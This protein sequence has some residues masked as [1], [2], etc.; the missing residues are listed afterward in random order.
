MECRV[1]PPV[2]RPLET[3]LNQ[4]SY[5]KGPQTDEENPLRG[6]ASSSFFYSF[7]YSSRYSSGFF[8]LFVSTLFHYPRRKEGLRQRNWRRLG[9]VPVMGRSTLHLR[10]AQ[11]Q[12]DCT[13]SVNDLV[14]DGVFFQNMIYLTIR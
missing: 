4:R 3:S 7:C 2:D 1:T 9:R 6:L 12:P 10:N 14:L 11:R 8:P 13:A 5:E